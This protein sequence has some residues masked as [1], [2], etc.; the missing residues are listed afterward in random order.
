[1]KSITACELGNVYVDAQT[2]DAALKDREIGWSSAGILERRYGMGQQEI[3][4]EIQR[5][6]A[7]AL[8][9]VTQQLLDDMTATA[10]D[11]PV[12]E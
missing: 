2:S 7:E 12:N 8:D 1:M 5:R 6:R 9:P 3:D 4:K 10:P 11:A